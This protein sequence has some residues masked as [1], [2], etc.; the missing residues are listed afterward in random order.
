MGGAESQVAE[1]VSGSAAE[2]RKSGGGAR[3]KCRGEEV[4]DG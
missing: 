2:G 4:C 1:G 3:D